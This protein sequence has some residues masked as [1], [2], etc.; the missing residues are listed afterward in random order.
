MKRNKQILPDCCFT[1]FILVVFFFL[2]LWIE[3]VFS[4]HSVVP[5]SFTLAVFLISQKTNGYAYGIAASFF[6]VLALNFAFTFPYFK[7]NFTIPENLVSAVI[8]LIVTSMS[9]AMTIKVK[10]N[11]KMKAE[12]E[13]EKMKANLLRAVSHDLRTPLTAIYGSSSL[14]ADQYDSLSKE[15]RIS[16][17]HG[18]TEDCEWLIQMIENLLSITRIDNNGIKIQ[19]SAV[20]LEELIDAVIVKYKK[21]Y[22]LQPLNVTIPDKFITIPMDAVLIQQVLF[23][24]MENAVI[25]AEGM[26]ELNLNVFTEGEHAVFEVVDNGCGIEKDRLTSIFSGYVDRKDIHVDAKKHTMGIGLS[27][28]ASIIKAH[29]GTIHV[30]NL[31]TGGCR[32][33]FILKLETE[34][35]E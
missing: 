22:P 30:E 20:V 1:L 8:M 13:K 14:I 4:A 29:D 23:N 2:N 9:S 11:E 18:I 16:L 21:R 31:S 35:Y 12:A 27:T 7:F 32:F 6:C 17:A 33:Y 28:C 10:R 34:E 19:K 26:T 25:H 3:E 24:M 15:Q 5:A